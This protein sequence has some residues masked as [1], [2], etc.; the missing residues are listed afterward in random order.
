MRYTAEGREIVG[1]N[2]TCFN[3]RP[4]Y[5]NPGTEGVALAGDRPMVRLLAKSLVCGGF[6][7]AIVRGGQGKWFHEYAEVE[8]RYRCG[9]MTWH[10]ADTGLPNVRVTIET[11]PLKDVAG[12][13]L[14]LNASGLQA[15]DRLVWA[16]GGAMNEE[17]SR[18]CWDPIMCGNP[19]INKRGP[20]K[21]ELKWSMVADWCRGNRI[22][23]DDQV[24]RLSATADAARA[25]IGK[26]D[27]AGRLHAADASAFA[28]PA[29]LAAA[30]ADKLPM[31]CGVMDLKPGRDE[32]FWALEAAPIQAG[33]ETLQVIAPAKAFRDAVAYLESI[34]RV[35]V[36]TPDPRLDAA[37]AAVCHPID[38][39]CDRNPFIFRHGCMAYSI[40]FLGWR[41]ICGSTACGWHERVKGNAAYYVAHQVKEDH[42][43]LQPQPDVTKRR[44]HEG[45]QSRFYGRGR[46]ANSPSLYDTQSQ[47]FD[48]T[49]RDWRRRPIPSWR[50]SSAPA[51]ELQLEWARERFDPDD[52]GLYES[53]I[54]TLPTD[55]VWYNGGGSVEESAYAY[56]GH[57][58]ARDMARRAGAPRPPPHGITRRRK[59][60]AAP[61]ATCCGSTIEDILARMS[62]RAGTTACMAMPGC[63]ASFCRSTPAWPRR[64]KRS[65]R[66]TTP[67][68]R[69]NA[70]ACHSAASCA[71]CRTGCPRSGRCTTCSVATCG[72]WPWPI[73]RRD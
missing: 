62:N 38:A 3:N 72:T 63:T 26:S 13:A 2:R 41:V 51:L 46:I 10:I 71:N 37:V 55:S 30:A 54:N 65:N 28:S 14:K 8:S 25:T 42:V 69:W 47:F 16:F 40:Q 56:Y 70:F 22:R 43:R 31:V 20:P 44:C 34:E 66:C 6:Y 39:A 48:Q 57:L 12:F 7:A 67:N 4:L 36:D 23:I 58:A 60:S 5:C 35:R 11:A 49:I 68:G 15:G 53:Y 24:F 52:D 19:N 64:S 45:P 50:K 61:S 17:N 9:R 27:R 1:R 18:W 33:T 73:F 29:V 59:K 21:P 32:I